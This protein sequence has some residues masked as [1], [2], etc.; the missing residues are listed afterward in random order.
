MENVSEDSMIQH[1]QQGVSHSSATAKQGWH[2]NKS[3]RMIYR[4]SNNHIR[5]QH[6]WSGRVFKSG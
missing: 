4:P 5:Q 2:N 6:G 3:H 1:A